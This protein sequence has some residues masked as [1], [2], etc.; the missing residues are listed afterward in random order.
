[1]RTRE[2]LVERGAVIELEAV[3]THPGP[4]DPP[5]ARH[6]SWACASSPAG[7]IATWTLRFRVD[8]SRPNIDVPE[9]AMKPRHVLH[10]AA[11]DECASREFIDAAPRSNAPSI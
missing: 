11:D 3:D 9:V 10:G 7:A 4:A 8:A 2:H 6:S 1:M 5:R